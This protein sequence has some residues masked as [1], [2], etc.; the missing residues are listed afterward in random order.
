MVKLKRS[1]VTK[2]KQGLWD[3]QKGVCPLCLKDLPQELSKCN[4]PLH[5]P[6]TWLWSRAHLDN[7]WGR[8]FKHKGHTPFCLSHNPCLNLVTSDLL[9][10]TIASSLTPSHMVKRQFF[11]EPYAPSTCFNVLVPTSPN[12]YSPFGSTSKRIPIAPGASSR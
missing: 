12:N 9:S 10:F 7:S 6:V 3:K 11:F 2:F 8:S 4:S 5:S 1:E